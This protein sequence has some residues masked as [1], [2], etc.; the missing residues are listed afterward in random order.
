MTQILKQPRRTPDLITNYWWWGKDLGAMGLMRRVN[1]GLKRKSA[2]CHN[3]GRKDQKRLWWG[4]PLWLTIRMFNG[5]CP[6]LHSF[7]PAHIDR[8]EEVLFN[9]GPRKKVII[10]RSPGRGT[11]KFH[12][13][14][15]LWEMAGKH[16][17]SMFNSATFIQLTAV[18]LR[19]LFIY[20]TTNQVLTIRNS[21]ENWRWLPFLYTSQIRTNDDS[22]LGGKST[23]KSKVS[24]ALL[25]AGDSRWLH[26]VLRH[27]IS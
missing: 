12:A 5:L 20:D 22:P 25:L 26:I 10:D 18:L 11:I 24:C 15:M 3:W 7:P 8:R 2:F 27:L 9:I 6:L 1:N 13:R 14:R 17:R 16:T 19:Q 23:R 21:N 4:V